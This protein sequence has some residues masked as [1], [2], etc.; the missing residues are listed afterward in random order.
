[1]W[2]ENK[3]ADQLHSFHAFAIE[4]NMFS[5][6]EL[7]IRIMIKLTTFGWTVKSSVLAFFVVLLPLGKMF[8]ES[9]VYKSA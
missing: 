9:S 1:M 5:H 2:S 3:G 4:K 6:E 7:I 8:R